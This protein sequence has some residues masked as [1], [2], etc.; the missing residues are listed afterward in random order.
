MALVI[1]GRA[2]REPGIQVFSTRPLLDSGF[3]LRRPR[4]AFVNIADADVGTAQTRLCPPYEILLPHTPGSIPVLRMT[5]AAS[6]AVR[7]RSSA[8]PAS[9]AVAPLCTPAENT[10][11]SWMSAGSAPR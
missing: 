1:P 7:K 4:N 6:G 3:R 9:A 10:V 11:T 2:Q 5:G 8:R